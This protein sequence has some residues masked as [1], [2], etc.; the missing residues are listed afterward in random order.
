MNYQ[1]LVVARDVPA[2]KALSVEFSKLRSSKAARAAPEGEAPASL[3]GPS[4]AVAM[5]AIDV[6]LEPLAEDDENGLP[7]AWEV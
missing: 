7:S 4:R 1:R 2:L 5:G 6:L 3:T